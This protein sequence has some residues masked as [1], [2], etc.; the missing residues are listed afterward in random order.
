MRLFNKLIH[1]F[2]T[3]SEQATYSFKCLSHLFPCRHRPSRE[4]EHHGCGVQRAPDEERQRPS[5]APH[6][7][8]PGQADEQERAQTE[9]HAHHC[10]SPH[11][12]Y[13]VLER[14]LRKHKTGTFI[15][16]GMSVEKCELRR[17]LAHLADAV[18]GREL[19]AGIN[20]I[21]ERGT[22]ST[23]KTEHLI[24]IY[25]CKTHD[26]FFH[27]SVHLYKNSPVCASLQGYNKMLFH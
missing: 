24:I 20:L 7:G 11:M 9:N 23:G 25:I 3:T 12:G 6:G 21:L 5:T 14:E 19:S 16:A 15:K 8:Q 26:L 22:D 4:D 1:D 18:A 27:S 17:K 2:K 13:R 10:Q